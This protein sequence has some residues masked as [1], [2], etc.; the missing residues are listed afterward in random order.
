MHNDRV[1]RVSSASG[2]AKLYKKTGSEM[3]FLPIAS[4]LGNRYNRRKEISFHFLRKERNL[5]HEL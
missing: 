4:L 2:E 5:T 3:A 1:Q